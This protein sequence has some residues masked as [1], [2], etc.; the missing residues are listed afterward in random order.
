LTNV[1]YIYSKHFWTKRIVDIFTGVM[2][3]LQ[4]TDLFTTRQFCFAAQHQTWWITHCR[5]SAT[6][7]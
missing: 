6:D 1:V 5:L 7:Y 3:P 2:L 4:Y